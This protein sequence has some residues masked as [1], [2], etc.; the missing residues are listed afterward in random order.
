MRLG[1]RYERE[2]FICAL[3]EHLGFIPLTDNTRQTLKSASTSGIRQK[4]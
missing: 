3:A 4:C 2:E 1:R